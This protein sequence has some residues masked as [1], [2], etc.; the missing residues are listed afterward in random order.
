MS[1]HLRS[2]SPGFPTLGMA[3]LA[4]CGLS[5]PVLRHLPVPL[6]E[7]VT[8][9]QL[10]LAADGI[11]RMHCAET[12]TRIY[13]AAGLV[14]RFHAPRLAHHMTVL[15]GDRSDRGRAH[16]GQSDL[17]D[18]PSVR[19]SA[20]K[21]A[22][23]SGRGPSGIASR[24][25]FAVRATRRAWQERSASTAPYDAADLLLPGDY[26][27][28]EPFETV[29]RFVRT[30]NGWTD[31]GGRIRDPSDHHRTAALPT[32]T[33]RSAVFAAR[34]GVARTASAGSP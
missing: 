6:A 4:L 31:A 16:R 18:L 19:R 2:H 32:V 24:T 23:P 8:R 3:T 9:R 15:N 33:V 20:R 30:G 22:W 29:A 21:G 27:R 34:P 14:L 25:A 26:S 10:R 1:A 17:L 11:S 7:R 12:A 5:E 28:A 13:A